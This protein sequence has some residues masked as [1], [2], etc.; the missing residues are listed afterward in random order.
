[1]EINISIGHGDHVK[2]FQGLGQSIR[3]SFYF[4]KFQNGNQNSYWPYCYVKNFESMWQ[5]ILESFYFLKFQNG[6]QNRMVKDV[7]FLFLKD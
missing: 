3:E 1:M 5:S 6:N 7:P 2:N 4:L